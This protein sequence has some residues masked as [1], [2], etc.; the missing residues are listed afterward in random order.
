MTRAVVV[1]CV[2]LLGLASTVE[3]T[4]QR[5]AKAK[6]EFRRFNPCPSTGEIRGRCPGYVIDHVE[7]LRADDLR[8]VG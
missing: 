1:V 5:S 4:T 7:P 8:K 3:A 2:V 6:A